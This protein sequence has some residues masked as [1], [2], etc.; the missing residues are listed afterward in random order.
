MVDFM[1]DVKRDAIGLLF[2][3]IFAQT[4]VPNALPARSYVIIGVYTAD[5]LKPVANCA[6]SVSKNV[7]G[8]AG[9]TRAQKDV[10]SSAIGLDV[11]NHVGSY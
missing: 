1:L 3:V 2:V 8:L 9:I 5:V 4:I 6:S 11:T 7:L 10:L